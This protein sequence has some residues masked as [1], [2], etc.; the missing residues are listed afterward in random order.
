MCFVGILWLIGFVMFVFIGVF[1][2]R[3]SQSESL[4]SKMKENSYFVLGVWCVAALE[5]LLGLSF[6]TYVLVYHIWLNWKG[7]STRQHFSG[8]IENPNN[9]IFCKSLRHKIT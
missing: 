7:V 1:S 9:N 2:W 8:N 5:S 6:C 3:W 4:V